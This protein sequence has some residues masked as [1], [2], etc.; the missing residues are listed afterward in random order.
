MMEQTY[1]RILHEDKKHYEYKIGDHTA[2]LEF[3]RT[4]DKIDL[5]HPEVPPALSGN[6][7][8]SVLIRAVLEGVKRLERTLVPLCP[9]VAL[10]LKQHPQWKFPVLK[11]IN[12]E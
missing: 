12:I 5:T 4:T 3:I 10:Y 2:I 9:F 11:G 7:I 1:E 6:G 8:G